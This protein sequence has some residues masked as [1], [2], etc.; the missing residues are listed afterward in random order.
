VGF[1]YSGHDTEIFRYRTMPDPADGV[2]LEGSILTVFGG[3]AG[4]TVDLAADGSNL[5]ITLNGST[6]QLPG[7]VSQ[8]H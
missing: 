6:V 4:N 5:A 8:P 3:Q 2:R 7:V 1:P